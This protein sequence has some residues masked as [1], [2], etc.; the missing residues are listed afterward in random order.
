MILD[1]TFDGALHHHFTQEDGPMH[2]HL[3]PATYL[4]QVSIAPCPRPLSGGNNVATAANA[5]EATH[6]RPLGN[7]ASPFILLARSC[8]HSALARSAGFEALDP[9]LAEY[10]ASSA[11]R[12]K[13]RT[14]VGIIDRRRRC[15]AD[16]G[17]L[18]DIPLAHGMV[19]APRRPFGR[20]RWF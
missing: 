3:G 7:P 1:I 15:A 10:T 18:L 16:P 4:Q 9:W 6:G 14:F 20:C 17:M 8:R 5:H 2:L 13:A 11:Y 12:S 19:S